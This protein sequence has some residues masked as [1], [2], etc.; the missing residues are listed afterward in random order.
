MYR[1]KGI[2]ANF[3][4]HEEYKQKVG[5]NEPVKIDRTNKDPKLI[6]KLDILTGAMGQ[7]EERRKLKQRVNILFGAVLMGIEI[8][9][10][11]RLC[12]IC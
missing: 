5:G 6:Q 8:G 11:P 3:L 12:W 10:L 1:I 9:S 2:S 7:A 4:A